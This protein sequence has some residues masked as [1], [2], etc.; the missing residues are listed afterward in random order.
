MIQKT[1]FEDFIQCFSKNEFVKSSKINI[2]DSTKISPEKLESYHKMILDNIP[3]NNI[4]HI[5]IFF[6]YSKG[7]YSKY[8]LGEKLT[9]NENIFLFN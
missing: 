5:W 8:F 9:K 4:N 3:R 2:V 7:N 1:P 6:G